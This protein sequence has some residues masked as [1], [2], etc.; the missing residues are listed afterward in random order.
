MVMSTLSTPIYV[1]SFLGALLRRRTGFVVT[2]KGDSASPDRLTTF[3]PGLR[4]AA[5]YVTLLLSAPIGAHVHGAMW[6]WPAINLVIC[7]MPPAIWAGQ[8]HQRRRAAP[9]AGGAPPEKSAE[10]PVESYA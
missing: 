5:F 7:L 1:S 3:A 10:E 2:P 8:E 6:L 9:P 4:W